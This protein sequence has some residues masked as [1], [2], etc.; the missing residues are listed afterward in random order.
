MH[1]FITSC[2]LSILEI[3][4]CTDSGVSSV[5]VVPP[6]GLQLWSLNDPALHCTTESFP[7][8]LVTYIL[9]TGCVR[10]FQLPPLHLT[11]QSTS[12]V[13]QL[14]PF[15]DLVSPF[16]LRHHPLLSSPTL[17][18]SP[19]PSRRS[20]DPSPLRFGTAYGCSGTFRLHLFTPSSMS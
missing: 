13:M 1:S 17:R 11:S 7:T 12:M 2:P 14:A 4:G 15:A 20:T 19:P 10:S 16:L 8:S 6:F 9:F 3:L 5:S 18:A